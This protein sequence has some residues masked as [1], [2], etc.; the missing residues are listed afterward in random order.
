MARR[1]SSPE[2][3]VCDVDAARPREGVGTVTGDRVRMLGISKRGNTYLRTL[4]I[5]GVRSVQR[6]PRSAPP[7]IGR[8][9]NYY[10]NKTRYC[11]T[12]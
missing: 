10:Q 11:A 7:S 1:F 9:K 12:P 3:I 2:R 4:L 6:N 8:N 5:Y